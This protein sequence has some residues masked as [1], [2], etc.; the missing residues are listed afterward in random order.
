MAANPQIKNPNSINIGDPINIPVPAEGGAPS[1][2]GDG[3]VD[4]AS[5]AP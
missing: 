5:Q 3:T 2:S 4:G 1:G